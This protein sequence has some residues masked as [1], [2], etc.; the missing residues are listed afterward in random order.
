MK[1]LDIKF[2]MLKQNVL[3]IRY[4]IQKLENI[5]RQIYIHIIFLLRIIICKI[6]KNHL[7]LN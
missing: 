7:I 1:Q 3:Y 5:D 4:K 2:R 6:S